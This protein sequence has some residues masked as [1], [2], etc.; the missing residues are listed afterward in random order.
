M[1]F[2]YPLPWWLAV[3]LAAAIGA[4][5]FVEYRRPLSP[6]TSA[7]RDRAGARGC[8]AEQAA[9]GCRRTDAPRARERAAEDRA[10][11]GAGVARGHRRVQCRRR[12]EAGC[13]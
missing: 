4:A 9:C 6:L 5:A 13:G 8:V 2:A 10:G 7:Q 12:A 1:H 11:A 3:I